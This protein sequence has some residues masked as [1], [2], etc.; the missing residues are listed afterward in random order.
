[1]LSVLDVEDARTINNFYLRTIVK[2][3][4][5]FITSYI[6]STALQK[7]KKYIFNFFRILAF[8]ITTA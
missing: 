1:M 5:M 2:M 3:D 4:A 8:M 7:T 6:S